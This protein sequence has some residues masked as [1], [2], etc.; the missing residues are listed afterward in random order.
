VLVD[1]GWQGKP[2]KLMLHADRNGFFYVF[3]RENGT[4]LLAKPFVRQITWA[5][6]IGSDRRPIKL[7]NQRGPRRADCRR[8]EV[9]RAT[10]VVPDEPDLEGVAAGGNILAFALRD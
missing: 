4:L 2:R 3:D 9:E 7:P 6:G 1:A 10:L 5:S 8:R